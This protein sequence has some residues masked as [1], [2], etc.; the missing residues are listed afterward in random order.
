MTESIN[1]TL[2]PPQRLAS[3]A[4]LVAG[5]VAGRYGL[6]VERV[7]ELQLALSTVL[8]A[9]E[10][11]APVS[12]ELD[13]DDLLECRVGPLGPDADG[14]VPLVRRLAD[15]ASVAHREGASWLTMVVRQGVDAS[16]PHA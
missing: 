7:G 4:T 16:A 13:V 10:T 6:S 5:G 14:L 15:E 1:L 8:E 2:E 3:V 12:V 11:S 9:L